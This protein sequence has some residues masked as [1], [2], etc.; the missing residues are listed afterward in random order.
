MHL[1]YNQLK[2]NCMGVVCANLKPAS[3]SAIFNFH[4][5]FY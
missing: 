1:N 5:K 2:M 3:Q 4:P